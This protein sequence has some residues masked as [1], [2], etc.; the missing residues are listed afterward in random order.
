MCVLYCVF[1]FTSYQNQNASSV[2]SDSTVAKEYLSSDIRTEA[3][4]LVLERE[5]LSELSN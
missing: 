3:N 4:R 2:R 1:F 5:P